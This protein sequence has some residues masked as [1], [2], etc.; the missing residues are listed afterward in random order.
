M[1]SIKLVA[2][3][4]IGGKR[5]ITFKPPF[6]DP[7]YDMEVTNFTADQSIL[8]FLKNNPQFG[9]GQDFINEA[10][11]RKMW[12]K[13]KSIPVSAV[14][15]MQTVREGEAN[16]KLIEQRI[17]EAQRRYDAEKKAVQD[18]FTKA[19]GGDR[20]TIPTAQGDLIFKKN[21]FTS[22][23][24]FMNPDLYE[25]ITNSPVDKDDRLS[26]PEIDKILEQTGAFENVIA[27]IGALD[28]SMQQESVPVLDQ[29]VR[30]GSSMAAPITPAP[31]TKPK[32]W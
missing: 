13:D 7:K 26:L 14:L 22:G 23:F 16:R 29:A 2:Q 4:M 21:S 10:D 20:I 25:T 11:E 8:P 6:D 24:E 18:K 30:S 3:K 15:D 1:V 32:N 31:S 28:M 17:E 27:G 12:A 5:Y 19:S 9:R